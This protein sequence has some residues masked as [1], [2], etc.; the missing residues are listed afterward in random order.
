MRKLNEIKKINNSFL[1]MKNNRSWSEFTPS[2]T[3]R[4]N[5]LK[6]AYL[7]NGFFFSLIVGPPLGWTDRLRINSTAA[8]RA[9]TGNFIIKNSVDSSKKVS[10]D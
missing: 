3:K 7:L 4:N 8:R 10:L 1:S 6:R 9:G 5:W 2:L